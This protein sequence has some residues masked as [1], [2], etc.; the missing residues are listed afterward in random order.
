MPYHPSN[1]FLVG[2]IEG[3]QGFYVNAPVT[4]QTGD[5]PEGVLDY[6]IAPPVTH[7]VSLLGVDPDDIV[8]LNFADEAEAREVLGLP[9][10]DEDE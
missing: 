1:Y 2:E 8:Y 3:Q 7:K 4:E 9:P 5:L 6:S 10:V